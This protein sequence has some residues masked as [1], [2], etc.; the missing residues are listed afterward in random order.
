M[1]DAFQ[2]KQWVGEKY[3]PNLQKWLAKNDGSP[4][5]TARV[6]IAA[7]ATYWIG[8]V[9]DDGW[10]YGTRLMCVMVDG[11][12]A[13]VYAHPAVPEGVIEQPDFWAHYGAVGRCAVDQDHTRGFIGDETRWAVDGNTR[14]CLW[15]GDCR[16]T[17]RRWQEVVNR[18][19]WEIA[20]T[21][22]SP[23]TQLEQA[24]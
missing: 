2:P 20:P 10:F 11:R 4:W 6:W 16:Q 7:D 24:A 5:G 21:P 9:D 12:K 23:L 18:Q 14:E 22:N 8:W 3:S 15:C 17:L 13:E 19:A 1:T